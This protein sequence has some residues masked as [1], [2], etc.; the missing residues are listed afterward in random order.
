MSKYNINVGDK[1]LCKLDYCSIITKFHEGR[2]Y[3]VFSIKNEDDYF[4]YYSFLLKDYINNEIIF[5]DD[6]D[7]N[8]A[9]YSKSEV[10]NMKLKKL[11]N[12]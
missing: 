9:F 8:S 5:I 6:I 4:N 2:E 10:R 12:D 1:L 3:E 7:L 11:N